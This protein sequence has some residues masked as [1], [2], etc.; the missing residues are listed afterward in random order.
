MTVKGAGVT[1][2]KLHTNE[3]MDISPSINNKGNEANSGTEHGPTN[4]AE[5]ASVKKTPPDMSSTVEINSHQHPN[6]VVQLEDSTMKSVNVKRKG[7]FN[8]VQDSGIVQR[9]VSMS[10]QDNKSVSNHGSTSNSRPNLASANNGT[11]QS[12]NSSS[13][14]PK[15]IVQNR[16]INDESSSNTDCH[17][18][19]ERPDRPSSSVA[20]NPPEKLCA[21]PLVSQNGL[22]NVSIKKKGRFML[23]TAEAADYVSPRDDN[24]TKRTEDGFC[25]IMTSEIESHLTQNGTNHST[26]QPHRCPNDSGSDVGT[27]SSQVSSQSRVERLDGKWFSGLEDIIQFC[28]QIKL[29][30]NETDEYITQLQKTLSLL[31][32]KNKHLED[33]CSGLEKKVFEEKRLRNNAEVKVK[34]LKKRCRQLEEQNSKLSL[35]LSNGSNLPSALTKDP[36]THTNNSSINLSNVSSKPIHKLP[37]PLESLDPVYRTLGHSMG[38]TS[39]LSTNVEAHTILIDHSG[40]KTVNVNNATSTLLGKPSGDYSANYGYQKRSSEDK[41]SCDQSYSSTLG[42]PYAG[43]DRTDQSIQTL[44]IHSNSPASLS[45][46][47]PQTTNHPSSVH[48][49]FDPLAP[50]NSSSYNAQTQHSQLQPQLQQLNLNNGSMM[51]NC[52]SNYLNSMNEKITTDSAQ[53]NH[54][55]MTSMNGFGVNQPQQSNNKPQIAQGVVSTNF[56]VKPVVPE[57]TLY[58]ETSVHGGFVSNHEDGRRDPI[59]ENECV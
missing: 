23:T 17:S 34:S 55:N 39:V 19:S 10:D 2:S 28:D 15:S 21:K 48:S 35:K 33:C 37:M 27:L 18:N 38:N 41:I 14:L 13:S 56:Y 24:D 42:Q 59:L 43:Q 29:K 50:I 31:H 51:N 52:M 7:R 9:S 58:R 57:S 4:H 3:E 46:C 44:L 49:Q 8:I 45:T 26:I 5:N 11:T 1:D 36:L 54:F 47:V 12:N 20:A 30:A 6:G 22:L 40:P 25:Q 16:L 53:A 32:E